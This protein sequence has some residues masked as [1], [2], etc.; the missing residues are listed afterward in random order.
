MD[1]RERLIFDTSG[2]N[3]LANEPDAGIIAKCLGMGSCVRLTETNL[4]EIGA[5]QKPDRRAKLVDI[6]QRLV[7]AGECI[8]PHHWI[9]E[10]QVKLHATRPDI[11]NWRRIDPRLPA[12]ETEIARPQFL[13]DD[14]IAEEICSD[15][16]KAA[17]EFKQLFRETREAF[18][19]PKDQRIQITLTDVIGVSLADGSA[20]WRLA[21]DMYEHYSGIR[22]SE[23]AVRA[24]IKL[25]PPFDA[26]LLSTCVAQFHG[27]VRD[28]RVPALYDAG[29]LDLM[30]S[31]Y[32]PYC[33]RFVTRDD[34]QRNAL[35][36]I[37]ELAGLKTKVIA[38]VEFCRSWL[39]A[40]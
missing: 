17:D 22:P 13:N 27:S 9:I 14:S 1:C 21:A 32:L 30:C 23:E 2:L 26:M 3:A 40:A 31:T 25:C 20:H 8:G 39:L 6:C 7:G 33:D 4:A 12:L 29:P 28:F 15:F 18:P 24:F 10:E 34:G 37:A 35:A 19:I 11:F 5:T 16:E 38:Y 36:A